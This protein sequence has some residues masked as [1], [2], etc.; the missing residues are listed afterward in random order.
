MCPYHVDINS[1]K[2]IIYY[3]ATQINKYETTTATINNG[4]ITGMMKVTDSTTT[5]TAH[6]YLQ[7]IAKNCQT[8]HM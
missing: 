3:S 6:K 5:N 4:Y 1:I 7:N 8:R 2:C